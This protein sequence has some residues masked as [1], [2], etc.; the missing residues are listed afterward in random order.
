MTITVKDIVENIDFFQKLAKQSMPAR[1]AFKLGRMLRQVTDEYNTFQTARRS[2]FEHY[3][4]RDENGQIKVDENGNYIIANED[5]AAVN[6]EIL[7]LLMTEV[8]I[9][10]DPLSLNEIEDMMFTPGE[11]SVFKNFIEE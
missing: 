8:T 10:C 3:A 1:T 2:L 5:I 7:D 11:M 6:K 4:V 9:T